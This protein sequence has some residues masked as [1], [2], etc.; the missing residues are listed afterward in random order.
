MKRG[1][2][3]GAVVLV[4][5][6]AAFV[7]QQSASAAEACATPWWFSS[8]QWTWRSVIKDRNGREIYR[9]GYDTKLTRVM[10]DRRLV[11]SVHMD[12]LDPAC[13]KITATTLLVSCSSGDW[14]VWPP[15]G[16][17]RPL[18]PLAESAKQ[19]V[20]DACQLQVETPLY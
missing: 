8:G 2:I 19:L 14:R 12:S 13:T 10:G 17:I 18:G 11:L 7:H 16:K 3:A 20:K 6:A 15:D 5:V 1:W 9:S 4:L